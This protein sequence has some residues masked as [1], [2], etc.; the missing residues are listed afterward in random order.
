MYVL[1]LHKDKL[2]EVLVLP[3]KTL[4]NILFYVRSKT[5]F[6]IKLELIYMIIVSN[7]DRCYNIIATIVGR[8][9]VVNDLRII[10]LAR[11]AIPFFPHT[12][13]TNHNWCFDLY[14]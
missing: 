3:V 5:N 6:N 4:V 10:P 11:T 7:I 12:D 1:R 9:R 8:F 13:S 14:K 2:F